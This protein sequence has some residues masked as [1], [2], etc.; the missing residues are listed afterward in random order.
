[1][2]EKNCG[3]SCKGGLSR[4]GG[5]YPRG[6]LVIVRLGNKE[7]E[8]EF[9]VDTGAMYLV[10]SKALMPVTNDYIMVRGQ[11]ANLKAH[12]FANY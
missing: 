1:M 2:I 10:L 9:L 8:V 4:T 12:T 11:L 5:P 6:P 3:C 7:K